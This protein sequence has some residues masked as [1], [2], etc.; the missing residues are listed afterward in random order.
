MLA[1]FRGRGWNEQR[2]I[3]L[4]SVPPRPLNP[5]KVVG[6]SPTALLYL[7]A[8]TIEKRNLCVCR[9]VL[10]L[11]NPPPRDNWAPHVDLIYGRRELR[12]QLGRVIAAPLGE[13]KVRRFVGCA[14][15]PRLEEPRDSGESDFT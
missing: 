10:T 12:S 5:V 13:P 8:L 2:K 7:S 6:A 9:T 11:I 14:S 3:F 4:G 1:D 15:S